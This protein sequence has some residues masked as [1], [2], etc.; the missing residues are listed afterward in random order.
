[1]SAIDRISTLSAAG[2]G[3]LLQAGMLDAVDV[4]EALLQRI[5]ATRDNH[6]FITV[7]ADRARREAVASRARLTAGRPLG[8]LDGVPIAWKDLIDMAGEVTTAASDLLRD[9]PP[10]G[11]DAAVVVNAA[12]AGM[13]SLGKVNLTEFAFS[14]LG[15]N[16]HFGT[17]ANP[18]DPL[19]PRAPGGSSS[20]SAVAVAMGLA[21]C[22]IGTDTG[23]SVRIPASFNGIV[24]FKTTHGR[25]PVDGLF[26]LA[27]GL[28][29]VGPLARSV[30]DCALLDATLRGAIST[31]VAYCPPERISLVVAE[32]VVLDGLD[33]AVAANFEAAL[34]RLAAA[35]ARIARRPLPLL[36]EAA[37][38]IAEHG[39]PIPIEAY[40]VHRARV[41]GP[42]AARMDRRVVDRIK[43]GQTRSAYD[44]LCI[45]E[46]RLRLARELAA[47][48]DGALLAM[49]TT[50]H[51]APEIAPLEADDQVFHAVN[52]KTLRNTTLGNFL[53]TCGLAL[54]SGTDARGLPT[55]ILLTGPGGADEALL[56]QGLAVERVLLEG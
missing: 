46:A 26:P 31:G 25:I 48:L 34:E 20:G 21:P 5:E 29:T 39:S 8:P 12:A 23:G 10:A 13:V 18:H 24:G 43:G 52:L 3:R 11:S 45:E 38:C 16:P 55:S 28:D 17:P 49:P 1:M 44:L 53:G 15:L 4:T 9:A 6:V 54:P 47:A 2:I 27:P 40:W 22:A 36:E 51:T 56:S 35:G 50:V 33:E 7:T 42:D 41:E 14:G 19:T 37:R 32:T 30:E